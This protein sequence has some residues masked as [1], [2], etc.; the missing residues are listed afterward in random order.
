MI[1]CSP[2]KR[3]GIFCTFCF[4]FFLTFVFY[5]TVYCIEYT[6]RIFIFLHIKKHSYTF[7][8]VF[9]SSKAFSVSLSCDAVLN[10]TKVELE[11]I[12]DADMCLFFEK[13]MGGRVSYI[14]NGYS[15]KAN[16]KYLK[17]YDPKQESKHMVY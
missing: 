16:Y 5:L 12:S 8:L 13:D 10:M 3:K 11:L 4:I 15:S 9:K 14:S 17:Y 2:K 7:L 6:F 1:W